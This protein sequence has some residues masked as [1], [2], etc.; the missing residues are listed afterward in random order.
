MDKL[1][2]HFLLRVIIHIEQ[3]TKEEAQKICA[4]LGDCLKDANKDE[5]M[6]KLSCMPV[7]GRGMK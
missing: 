5:V 2:F 6:C 1:K 4:I 7:R 3:A